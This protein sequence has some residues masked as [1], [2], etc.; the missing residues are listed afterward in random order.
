MAA[1]GGGVVLSKE[2]GMAAGVEISTAESEV[3]AVLAGPASTSCTAFRRAE[4]DSAK[5]GDGTAPREAVALAACG[6]GVLVVGA[7]GPKGMAAV[8]AEDEVVAGI[9]CLTIFFLAEV[10]CCAGICRRTGMCR[11]MGAVASGV[12]WPCV[13]CADAGVPKASAAPNA[14][15]AAPERKFL[16]KFNLLPIFAN[17]LQHS[18][19]Q[20]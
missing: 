9:F 5:P 10:R 6:F 18:L 20:A 3:A 8:S 13:V 14:A 17:G 2:K 1:G 11:W 15:I 7:A 16:C 4:R 12:N 19:G